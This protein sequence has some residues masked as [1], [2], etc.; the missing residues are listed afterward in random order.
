MADAPDLTF[1]RQQN[2]DF[3][4]QIEATR[5]GGGGGDGPH[6]TEMNVERIG[7]VEGE[8]SGLKHGQNMTL[9]GLGLV[10]A[11]LTVVVGSIVVFGIY[12]LQRIDQVGDRITA[13]NDKVNELPG[14]ISAELRDITKTLAEVITATKQSQQPLPQTPPQTP[15]P[16]PPSPPNI[17]R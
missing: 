4:K 17:R 7:R 8:I 1:L 6:M 5:R 13:L 14:K 10:I 15:Q 11:L 16:Q 9:G 12:E 2:A 3:L